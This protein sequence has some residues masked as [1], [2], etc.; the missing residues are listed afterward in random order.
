M[1]IYT[2]YMRLNIWRI[3]RWL[4]FPANASQKWW[5]PRHTGR[6][7]PKSGTD[8]NF[9]KSWLQG[10]MMSLCGLIQSAFVIS[11]IFMNLFT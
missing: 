6:V 1:N 4:P 9:I 2:Q 10:R 5:S 8:D 7:E 3:W 11:L